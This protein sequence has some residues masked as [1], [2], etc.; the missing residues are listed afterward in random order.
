MAMKIGHSSI[1]ENG[2]AHGG[3]AGDQNSKEVF[4][5]DWYDKGWNVLLRPKT[6]T[7]AEKSAKF[8]EAACANNNIGYDQYQRN[9]LYT[10]AQAV[11][12]DASKIKTKC[13]CDCSSFMHVAAIAGGANLSYGSNGYTTRSMV[14]A[15]VNSGSYEKLTAKKYLTSDKELKRG[16]ILVKEGSHT[17]MVLGDGSE[18]VTVKPVAKP[19]TT[20]T[21]SSSSTNKR[22]A[23]V[24]AGQTWMNNTYGSILKKYKGGLVVVDGSYGNQSRDAAVCIW[25]YLVNKK[26]GTSLTLTNKNFYGTSKAAGKKASLKK[27]SKED[28]VMILQLILSAKGYYT[29][30]MDGSFGSI[31]DS[32]VRAYQKKKGL[33]VDGLVG[34]ETWYSLFN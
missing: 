6:S 16:D 1:D 34:G 22:V 8:V 21:S 3:A 32:A 31:T 33:T 4:I 10:Q 27:G 15:F 9:T 26:L 5:R 17:V 29:S 25:K 24:K 14:K 30:D 13:E 2:K 28:L 11:K 23:N 7:L 19:T 12:F 18:T 20:T